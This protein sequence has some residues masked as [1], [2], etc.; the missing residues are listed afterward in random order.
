MATQT[1][2]NEPSTSFN[3]EQ[4]A[5]LADF[6][7]TRRARLTP[8]E[9]GLPAGARRKVPGL[10]RE[11]VAELAGIGATWYTSRH[12]HWSNLPMLYV[13]L[14]R[15]ARICLRSRD[16]KHLPSTQRATM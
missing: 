4:R 3:A 5:E 8:Q 9:V 16:S 12:A 10:R 2:T 6:L 7:R 13:W 14:R 15:S 11:E 1:V